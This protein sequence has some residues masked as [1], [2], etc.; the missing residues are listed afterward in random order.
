MGRSIETKPVGIPQGLLEITQNPKPCIAVSFGGLTPQA[1][2]QADEFL[3]M[4]DV[5][6]SI[7]PDSGTYIIPMGQPLPFQREVLEDF[8]QNMG[9][10]IV[11]PPKAQ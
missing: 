3:A 6:F 2:K 1:Q 8:I 4:S 10:T 5:S 11:Q 9:G 7:D